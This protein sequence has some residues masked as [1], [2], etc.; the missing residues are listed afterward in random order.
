M[1]ARP[2]QPSPLGVAAKTLGIDVMTGEV[3]GAL[4]EAG[5]EPVLLKGP[6]LAEWLYEAGESRDYKDADLLVDPGRYEDAEGVL[7]SLGFVLANTRDDWR[8]LRHAREWAD[9]EGRCIDLHRTLPGVR[10]LEPKATWRRVREHRVPWSLPGGVTVDALDEPARTLVVAL[11]VTHHASHPGLRAPAVVELE[12]AVERL[13]VE[14]W[15]RAA[16]LAGDLQAT[17]DLAHA[18]AAVPNGPP[19]AAALELPRP[20][21]G[22]V[23]SGGLERVLATSGAGGR[24]RVLA[25]ALVPTPA[26]LRWVSPLARRGRYGLAAAY[27]LRPAWLLGTVPAAVRAWWSNRNR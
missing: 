7:A 3:V 23:E 27:L 22:E 24:L 16:A 2:P 26:H 13:P 1:T 5:I 6:V 4:R 19:L 8:R 15:S 17:P 14:L 10:Y 20:T 12:R 11:H 9:A 18:L 21:S 25:R